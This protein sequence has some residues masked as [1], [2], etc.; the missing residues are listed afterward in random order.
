MKKSIKKRGQKITN[1]LSNLSQKASEGSREHIQENV[2]SRISHIKYIRLF[3]FEWIL[4]VFAVFFLGLTQ[5]FWYN[6]SFATET[7]TSGGTYSEATLDKINSLNPIFAST[8]SERTLSKLMFGRLTAPD[9]SGHTGMD[10]ASSV[11]HDD[12]GKIWTVKLKPNLKWSDGQ[13][14][15]NA[16]V[17]YTTQLIQNPTVKSSYSSKLSGVSVSETDGAIVFTL[18]T[19]YVNFASSLD[20]PILPSHI[21]KDVAPERLAEHEFSTSPT[22]SGPFIYNASRTVGTGGEQ[23]VYLNANENYYKGRPLL[24][25]FVVHAYMTTDD[26]ISAVNSGAVTATAELSVTDGDAI[27]DP[28]VYDKQTAL[29][30]GVY[31]FLN[32]S[33]E[34]LSNVSI[35]QAI[36]QGLDMNKLRSYDHGAPNLN[37]PILSSQLPSDQFPELP[38]SDRAAAQ[39]TIASA[40]LNN[41]TPLSIVATYALGDIAEDLKSQLIALGLPAEV[42]IYDAGQDFFVN[43]IRPRSYDILIYGIDLGASPDL[44]AY[45]HS[46]QTNSSGLNLSNFRSALAD[47]L[48]LASRSTLNVSLRNA[49]YRSFLNLWV[50]EV[51]A[52]GIYQ[53]NLSYYVD[54]DA[55]SFSEDTRLVSATDRFVDVCNWAVNTTT[56]NRTP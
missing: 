16:D 23:I 20:I 37:Y 45:Y 9:Y 39:Q 10:L 22:T 54:H 36:R 46:S 14:I 2:I 13:P 19:A 43:V 32:T 11:T 17:I 52:I 21:L 35:R 47:D 28:D 24:D 33:S 1:T 41:A 42:S 26:I 29:N 38:A 49:K 6:N 34:I 25:S 31:A 8:S 7:F 44:L 56:K 27:T 3:I 15:T 53:T 30:S 12:T 55:R 48:I 51:P 40:G 50:N 5:A 18:P 4:L